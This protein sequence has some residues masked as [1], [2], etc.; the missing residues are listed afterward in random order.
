MAIDQEFD[1]TAAGKKSP[2]DLPRPVDLTA[3]KQEFLGKLTLLSRLTIIY[4]DPIIVHAMVCLSHLSCKLLYLYCICIVS[5]RTEHFAQHQTIQS[6][7]R[8]P[9]NGR[10]LSALLFHVQRRHYYAPHHRIGRPQDDSCVAQILYSGTA[11]R[12]VFRN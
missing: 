5:V 8:S 7:C 6:D 3:L 2:N 1:H 11:P 4:Q 10:S 9:K 12:I